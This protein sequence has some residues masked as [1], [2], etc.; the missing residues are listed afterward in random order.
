MIRV[1]IAD[2][3]APARAKVRSLLAREPDVEVV[4]EA[5]DGA[6]TA[7]AIRRARPDL[8]LLDIQMPKLDG[9]GVVRAIGVEAMPLIVFITAYDEHALSAVEVHALDYLLKPFAP[10]RF[11]LVLE[12][13]RRQLAG[14]RP[15]DLGQRIERL[16]EA[17]RPAPRYPRHVLVDK[18]H[19]RQV[20]V[21]VDTI[22]RIVA[23]RNDYRLITRGGEF[24]R[25]GTMSDIEQ[26]L[27]PEKFLR[28]NRSEIVRLDAVAEFQPWFRGDYRVKM[29]D[30]SVLTWSRRYRARSSLES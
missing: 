17:V 26:K 13:V 8:V 29:K 14:P 28:I 20:L 19:E 12:R 10:S 16:L 5:A 2:D 15:A 3:E 11:T 30:G 21:P 22:D 27:D 9:F 23:D 1:L 18:G 7:A 24:M 4:A 6:E 25:R